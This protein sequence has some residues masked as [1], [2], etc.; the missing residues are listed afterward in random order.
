MLGAI[1]IRDLT[2]AFGDRV[3]LSDINLKAGGGETLVLIGP[4][5]C[6]KSTLLRAIAKIIP[7]MIPAAMQGEVAV[8]GRADMMFQEGNLLPWR[9]VLG[10]VRLGNELLGQKGR[11]EQVRQL[12][13]DVGLSECEQAYPRQL[14]GGMRQR[15]ALVSTLMTS[16]EVLLMD[17]PFGSLDALT[18]EDMWILLERIRNTGISPATIVMVTHSIEEAVVLADRILIMKACPGQIV[19][20]VCVDLPYPRFKDGILSE[21]CLSIVNRIRLQIR[22]HANV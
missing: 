16:P 2:V 5:G 7:N 17:E 11:E 13:K 1:D 20:E 22:E 15:V 10:N 8:S 19:E 9:D 6:G 21:A 4:S 12:L 14:S 18:R 3:V